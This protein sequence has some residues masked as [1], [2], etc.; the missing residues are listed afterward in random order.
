VLSIANASA[1]GGALRA[2]QA[3]GGSAWRDLFAVFVTPDA[4]LK[5]EPNAAAGAAYEKL[6]P[7]LYARVDERLANG[8]PRAV[9][10]GL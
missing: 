3:L 8:A 7:A 6:K 5:L 4:D 2:A 10:R 1:L 9:A